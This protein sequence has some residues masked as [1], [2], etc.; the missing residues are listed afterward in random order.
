M[1]TVQSCHGRAPELVDATEHTHT[2]KA[3]NMY[4]FG[5]IAFEVWTDTFAWH[6]SVC[7][8]KTG[9]HGATSI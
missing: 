2:T 3:S 7:S 6:R 1:V 8:L 9:S 4:D 5:L